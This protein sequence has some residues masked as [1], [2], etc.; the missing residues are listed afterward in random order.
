MEHKKENHKNQAQIEF[1]HHKPA[2]VKKAFI[3]THL[4]VI[5]HDIDWLGKVIAARINEYKQTRNKTDNPTYEPGRVYEI[6]PLPELQESSYLDF[7]HENEL[8]YVERLVLALTISASYKPQIFKPLIE[9]TAAAGN[10]YYPFGGIK[11]QNSTRFTPTLETAVFLLSGTDLSFRVYY[12]YLLEEHHPLFKKQ[13]INLYYPE[14][15][16]HHPYSDPGLVIDPAHKHYFILGMQPRLDYGKNFPAELLETDKQFSDLIINESLTGDLENIMR[17]VKYHKELFADEEAKRLFSPGYIVMF[18]GP[19]GTGKSMTA[20]LIGKECGVPVYR[21]NLSRVISKYIG[22]TEKNLERVFA[23]LEDKNV[24]L[25]FDEADALFGKRTEITDAKDRYANQEVSYLLQKI[26]RWNG[27]VILATNFNQ[28]LDSAFQR[29]IIKQIHFQP[30]ETS[31]LIQLWQNLLPKQ[32]SY[33]FPELPELLARTYPFTGANIAS[34][35]KRASI[36]ALTNNTNTITKA[37]LNPIIREECTR[38]NMM[39]IYRPL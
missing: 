4:S 19:P 20:S 21:I 38:N 35:L 8:G 10:D 22:E 33:D 14:N 29:R 11:K 36:D 27:V 37:I 31:E 28:N 13:I 2:Y 30:P 3:K 24:I 17:F 34:V 32:Y 12:E 1:Q 6:T 15:E 39:Q 25:F 5:M 16:A 18:H 7:I 9:E 26:E 23:R